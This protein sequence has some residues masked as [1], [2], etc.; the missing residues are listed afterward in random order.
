MR[1]QAAAKTVCFVRPLTCSPS[2]PAALRPSLSLAPVLVLR[3]GCVPKKVMW[4]TANMADA[5]HHKMHN[6]YGFDVGASA[7]LSCL[8]VL[9]GLTKSL[10]RHQPQRP[11]RPPPSS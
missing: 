8:R 1:T 10:A 11:V 4:Y 7:R 2:T 3:S 6:D 9:A 5:L